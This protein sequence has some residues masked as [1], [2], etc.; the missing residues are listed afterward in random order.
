MESATRLLPVLPT[1]AV[2]LW[3]F[4][5]MLICFCSPL[6]S[7]GFLL[8]LRASCCSVLA[9]QGLPGILLRCFMALC[10][11]IN[12]CSFG[13]PR[14]LTVCTLYALTGFAL[15]Q[16]ACDIKLRNEKDHGG[17]TDSRQDIQEELTEKLF[18]AQ[19]SCSYLAVALADCCCDP[20]SAKR[21]D[22]SAAAAKTTT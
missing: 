3:C 22:D 2:T 12:C 19:C 18:N 4:K 8:L 15:A 13:M 17:I 11:C 16:A 6:L 5:V 14:L 7:M 21:A 1:A 20:D 10:L 9:L